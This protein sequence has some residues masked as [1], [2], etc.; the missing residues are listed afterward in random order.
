MSAQRYSPRLG[1]CSRFSILHHVM[2]YS[3]ICVCLEVSYMQTCYP[4]TWPLVKI[5]C[6]IFAI[7]TIIMKHATHLYMPTSILCATV[8]ILSVCSLQRVFNCPLH[9]VCSLLFNTSTCPAGVDWGQPDGIVPFP[10]FVLKCQFVPVCA[11]RVMAVQ[12]S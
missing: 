3:L 11:S 9:D 6:C 8:S 7:L 2:L 12:Q 10:N 5:N 4:C 1:V